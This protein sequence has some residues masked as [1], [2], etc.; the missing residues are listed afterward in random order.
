MIVLPLK[1]N[2]EARNNDYNEHYN[3]TADYHIH[4]EDNRE[5]QKARSEH[6]LYLSCKK[7][8]C[9]VC[10]RFSQ[11]C[12]ETV[13]FSHCSHCLCSALENS[14]A[15]STISATT[16]TTPPGL[17]SQ[18]PARTTQTTTPVPTHV[19][20]TIETIAPTTLSTASTAFLTIFSIATAFLFFLIIF[21]FY[22]LT[23]DLNNTTVGSLLKF[24]C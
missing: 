23:K 15:T 1:G 6:E 19:P 10:F 11:S 22:I 2:E 8:S 24:K 4:Q 14:W 18:H 5:E 7:G 21:T 20:T 17:T 12:H 9:F 13:L 16:G 3:H